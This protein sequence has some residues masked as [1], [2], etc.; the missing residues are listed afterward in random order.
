VEP[1]DLIARR[2]TYALFVELGRA[3]LPAEVAS[4]TGVPEAEVVASWARLHEQHALVLDASGKAVRMANPFSGVPTPHR[5]YAAGRWWFANC[6]WDAFG[7]CAAL[8]VDGDIETTCPDCGDSMKIGVRHRQPTDP[9]PLFHC[10]VP[11]AAWWN[12]IVFT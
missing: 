6:G 8:G 10:L 4:A 3:P 9:A 7:I 2:K 1:A 5:V 11:A 12:D